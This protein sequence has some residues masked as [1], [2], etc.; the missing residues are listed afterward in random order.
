M[1]LYTLSSTQVDPYFREM[2]ETRHI[3]LLTSLQFL[4]SDI[5]GSNEIY[6]GEKDLWHSRTEAK[7]LQFFM[8]Y[9]SKNMN[10]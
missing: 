3:S 4:S 7:L 6:F 1:K 5:Q 9:V 8:A 2:L 10:D